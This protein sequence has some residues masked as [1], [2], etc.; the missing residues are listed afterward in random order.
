MTWLGLSAIEQKQRNLSVEMK[1]QP[2]FQSILLHQS[3]Y[4]QKDPVKQSQDVSFK[5]NQTNQQVSYETHSL[6]NDSNL[7]KNEPTN[8]GTINL[9]DYHK[10]VDIR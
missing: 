5:G 4:I 3:S 7:N 6:K 9:L 8:T 1:D 2:H 10:K